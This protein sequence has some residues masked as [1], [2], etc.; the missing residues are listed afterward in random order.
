VARR[1]RSESM[2]SEWSILDCL[3]AADRAVAGSDHSAE[4]RAGKKNFAERLSRELAQR[5]ADALREDFPGITPDEEGRGHERR[6]RTGKGVKKLDV[7]YSTPDLGLGLGVSIKTIN[8]ADPSSGR[9]TKNLTRID[10]ELRAEA[11]DY[12]ERQPYSVMIALIFLPESACGDG[13]GETPS[14]FGSAIKQ[15]RHRTNRIGPAAEAEL[16][17]RI[18]VACYRDAESGR[19]LTWFFDVM[20]APP[21]QGRPVPPFRLSFG[22]VLA[23]IR[24]SYDLR[25]D[26]PFAWATEAD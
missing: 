5:V 25:N 24:R 21:K 17:E 23:E 7:N 6:T 12:H 22:Q 20:E 16:F 8:A 4:D 18:F 9:Y 13:N 26:P 19:G 2:V 1:N 10:N 3:T 15:F 14:S 11:K